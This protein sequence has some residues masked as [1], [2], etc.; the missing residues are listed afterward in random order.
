LTLGV[1]F[2][3]RGEFCPLGGM[4][5]PFFHP[6]GWT[7]STVYKEEWNRWPSTFGAIFIRRGQRSSMGSNYTHWGSKFAPRGEIKTGLSCFEWKIQKEANNF[8]ELLFTCVICFRNFFIYL[9]VT[10]GFGTNIVLPI[11]VHTYIGR[12]DWANFCSCP[13]FWANVIPR[14]QSCIYF[15]NFSWATF[16]AIFYKLIWSPCY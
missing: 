5:T 8:N 10:F 2:A 7:L 12:P 13:N 9:Y 1:N 15:D 14:S 4:L 16:W 3:P 6:M 11:Y